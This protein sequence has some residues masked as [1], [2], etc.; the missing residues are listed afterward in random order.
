[1]AM[2]YDSALILMLIEYTKRYCYGFG[3]T[4]SKLVLVHYDTIA[5]ALSP[6]IE[7]QWQ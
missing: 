1:M 7:L 2:A 6:T 3:R 4:G 5:I